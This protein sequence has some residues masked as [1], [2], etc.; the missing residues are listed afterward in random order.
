M[1]SMKSLL[2]LADFYEANNERLEAARKDLLA[3]GVPYPQMKLLDMGFWQI[4]YNR[5]VEKS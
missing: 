1:F 5:N 3:F 2:K 4:G